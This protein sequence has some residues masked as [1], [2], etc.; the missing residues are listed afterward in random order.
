MPP[1]LSTRLVLAQPVGFS[2][3][4]VS[5]RNAKELLKRAKSVLQGQFVLAFGNKVRSLLF[6]LGANLG[7]LRQE[8]LGLCR[9]MHC[10]SAVRTGH[11]KNHLERDKVEMRLT[12]E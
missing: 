6:T 3:S 5:K 4:L 1:Q 11:C 9:S 2:W 8:T 7:A 12:M 10:I